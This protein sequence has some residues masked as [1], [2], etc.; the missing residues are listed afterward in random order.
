MLICNKCEKV[1]DESELSTHKD[2]MSYI[3]DEPYYETNADNCSC[4]G[5]LEEA[6]KCD[7]C[8]DYYIDNDT[9]LGW[10]YNVKVCKDCIERY[11]NKYTEA[12][13]ELAYNDMA[14]FIDWLVDKGEIEER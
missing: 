9:M 8:G 12:Y 11:K 2:L 3:G 1:I 5:E 13:D 14:D 4:G 7:C 6:T 10:R